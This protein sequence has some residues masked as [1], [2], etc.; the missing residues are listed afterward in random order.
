M[1]K[2]SHILPSERRLSLKSADFT[3]HSLSSCIQTFQRHLYAHTTCCLTESTLLISQKGKLRLP[4][5]PMVSMR[6]RWNQYRAPDVL[7][8]GCSLRLTHQR[9]KGPL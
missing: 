7:W 9:G 5:D 1:G 4:Q 2:R 8:G 6:R 3:A